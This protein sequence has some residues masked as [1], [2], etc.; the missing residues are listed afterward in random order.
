MN[1][2]TKT[3]LIETHVFLFP[4]SLSVPPASQTFKVKKKCNETLAYDEPKNAAFK[5]F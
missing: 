2:E 3:K 5:D 4:L 1:F